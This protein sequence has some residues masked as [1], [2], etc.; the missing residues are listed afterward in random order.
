M[1]SLQLLKGGNNK[2]YLSTTYEIHSQLRKILQKGIE[3]RLQ[4]VP[5]HKNI[6]G[7]ELAD[8]AA[9]A[10]HSLNEITLVTI[11]K[12]EKVRTILEVVFKFW[13]KNWHEHVRITN[14]G[15]HLQ[16]IKPSVGHWP[17]SYH[18]NRMIETVF[19]KLRIGHAN[20][21]AN[22]YRFNRSP[23]PLCD[24]GLIED[25]YHIFISCPQYYRQRMTLISKLNRLN[26]HFNTKNL[27]GGGNF[28]L[29]KQ[30][31]IIDL[32]AEYLRTIGKLYVL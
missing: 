11:P 27:L 14:K 26:V 15:K 29:N 21:N 28:E 25:V 20:F 4:F 23:T 31:K 19:A 7:N 16:N 30:S 9:N 24:C 1:S 6:E 3:V 8:L 10:A 5:S 13:E 2:S 17:W 32:T 12:D 22:N 18:P